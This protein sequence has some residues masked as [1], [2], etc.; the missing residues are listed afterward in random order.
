MYLLYMI[1]DKL[2]NMGKGIS[3]CK[4]NQREGTFLRKI[5]GD[6]ITKLEKYWAGLSILMHKILKV[7]TRGLSFGLNGNETL[8][9]YKTTAWDFY[10]VK[11]GRS[12]K[13]LQWKNLW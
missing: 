1:A 3:K 5:F 2:S 6:Y 7:E 12:Y 9:L 13:Y 11:D 10:M 4:C 8:F